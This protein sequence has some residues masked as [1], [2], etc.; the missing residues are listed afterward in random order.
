M[1]TGD[2]VDHV[3]QPQRQPT[4]QPKKQPKIQPKRQPDRLSKNFK[5]FQNKTIR[6][7]NKDFSRNL[8]EC[9]N[10]LYRTIQDVTHIS[11]ECKDFLR[12]L[13]H[14]KTFKLLKTFLIFFKSHLTMHKFC[15]CFY[16]Y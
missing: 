2:N 16:Y 6:K 11:Q 12:L 7:K 9:H 8:Q 1:D 15:A 14:F 4:R 5:M 13:K 10:I 3:G